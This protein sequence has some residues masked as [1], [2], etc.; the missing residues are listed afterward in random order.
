M[1][2]SKSS[3]KAKRLLKKEIQHH[4]KEAYLCIINPEIF[5]ALKYSF[6]TYRYDLELI[7]SQYD[8]L[9]CKK[10]INI[11]IS[12][13]KKCD[14]NKPI[15]IYQLFDF[16]SFGRLIHISSLKS[17]QKENHHY[18]K[19]LEFYSH[20]GFI[21]LNNINDLDDIELKLKQ[22][23]RETFTFIDVEY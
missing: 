10:L 4:L 1:D 14:F 5:K 9:V 22:Q 2:K 19:Y 6:Q 17:I 15:C 11:I 18:Q 20:H 23:F 3:I 12:N 16:Q 21:F 13:N 7:D 8:R